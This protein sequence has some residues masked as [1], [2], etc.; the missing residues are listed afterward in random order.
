MA[1][2]FGLFAP[3]ALVGRIPVERNSPERC[4]FALTHYEKRAVPSAGKSITQLALPNRLLTQ[5]NEFNSC[6]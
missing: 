5:I 3:A 2:S 1:A 4:C 6:K